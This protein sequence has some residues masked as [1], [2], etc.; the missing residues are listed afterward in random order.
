MNCIF[1]SGLIESSIKNNTKYYFCQS[2]KGAFFKT[3]SNKL[4]LAKYP[5]KQKYFLYVSIG[6]ITALS[7]VLMGVN[8]ITGSFENLE[9]LFFPII[10]AYS[11]SVIILIGL[12]LLSYINLFKCKYL[13]SAFNIYL[14]PKHKFSIIYRLAFDLIITVMIIVLFTLILWIKQHLTKN[15]RSAALQGFAHISL[16]HLICLCYNNQ[17]M[18]PTQQIKR[19][20]VQAPGEKRRLLLNVIWNILKRWLWN[21]MIH[22]NYLKI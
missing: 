11:F 20:P 10:I 17:G 2:C 3:S 18:C 15:K 12:N 13:L 4:K 1:C 8:M 21:N 22:L 19:Q 9:P 14:W 6:L 5:L 16:C 7:L